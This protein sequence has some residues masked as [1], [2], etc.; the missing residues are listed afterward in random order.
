MYDKP[1]IQQSNPY[2]KTTNKEN[3]VRNIYYGE[4]KSIDDPYGGRRIK[5]AI[6]DFDNKTPIENLPYA[7]PAVPMFVW[8]MPQV[9]EVVRIFIED[10]RYPQRGRHWMGSIISQPQK[11]AYDGYFT[12]LS[13]TNVSITSPS[14]NVNSYPDAA[15]V[16]P[17]NKDIGLIGRDNTDLLLK[18]KQVL[19][20]AGKHKI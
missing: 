13:T 11:I 20:R 18:E 10:T 4:V 6:P 1:Y 17:D 14:A 3:P 15:G 9:G 16:F 12:A 19:I 7:L 5:V 8:M 2:G